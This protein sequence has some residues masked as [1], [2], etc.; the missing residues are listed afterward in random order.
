MKRLLNFIKKQ[1]L[2]DKCLLFIM[3]VLMIQIAYTLFFSHA[4]SDNNNAVDV[5]IRTSAASVFGYF[6]G[7]NFVTEEESKKYQICNKSQIIV[8]TVICWFSLFLMVTV[9]NMN[10][11]RP[12]SIATLSQLRDFVASGVGFLVSCG[13]QKHKKPPK[14]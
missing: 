7:H 11:I 9:R 13:V 6:L 2:V 1:T 12:E 14:V 10:I 3:A 4:T 8:V 5:V